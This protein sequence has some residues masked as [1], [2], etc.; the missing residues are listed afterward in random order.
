MAI[1][2][3]VSTVEIKPGTRNHR[4]FFIQE[5][6]YHFVELDNSGWALICMNEAICY[7]VDPDNLET[8][9]DPDFEI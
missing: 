6:P 1:H 8:S 3:L 9:V 5:T 2:T 4:G 7:Y